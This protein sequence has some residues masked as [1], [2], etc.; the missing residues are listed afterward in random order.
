MM[1]YYIAA[2]RFPNEKANG[3][4]IKEVCNS[5]VQKTPVT[6]VVPNRKNYV[7]LEG[8]GLDPQI[9]I[10]YIPVIDFISTNKFGWLG[11]FGTVFIFSLFSGP[12]LLFKKVT[13]NK[14]VVITRD[15]TC[16]LLPALFFIPT[17]W[18]SHRGQWNLIVS[19]MAKL[20]VNFFVISNGLADFYRSKGVKNN[21]INVLPDG[22]DLSRYENLPSKE[23]ARKQLNIPQDKF[24]VVYNGHLHTWKGAD[25]L[26]EAAAL[27]PEH[28]EVI[29]MGGTDEDIEKFKNKYAHIQTVSVIGRR[30]DK[31]R[32]VYLRAADVLVIPNTA[33]N[34]ISAKYTSPLKLFGYM[35]TGTPIV[36]SDLP[37][38]REV[39]SEHE[40]FFAEPDNPKSFSDA[41]VY[42]YEHEEDAKKRATS[43][44]DLVREYSWDVRADKIVKI[45][46]SISNH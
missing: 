30:D 5:L 22:V 3:K 19:F 16:A 1:I 34:E 46:Q 17:A 32:P 18:E 10:V 36:A 38:I 42:A 20:K 12:Y 35:A 4:Q 40:S 31:T 29:F 33:K 45:L 44:R 43:A 6:I 37:S 24:I 9:R 2:V 26:A 23:E 11:W 39:I 7:S 13:G 21:N 28:S 8:F 14:P 15:F 41:M 27:L 25:I